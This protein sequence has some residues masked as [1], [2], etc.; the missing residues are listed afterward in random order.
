LAAF[1]FVPFFF[2][3]FFF[4]AISYLRCPRDRLE[5]H[6]GIVEL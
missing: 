4:V 2:A 6:A 5:R 1:F 3:A